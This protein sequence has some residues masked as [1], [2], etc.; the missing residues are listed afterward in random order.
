MIHR[1]SAVAFTLE[2]SGFGQDVGCVKFN[3]QGS[4]SSVHQMKWPELGSLVARP[5]R[6]SQV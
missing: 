5:R 4:P 2:A 6:D 3:T 1:P